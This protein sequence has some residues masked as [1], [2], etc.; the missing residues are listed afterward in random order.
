MDK[1]AFLLEIYEPGSDQT[2]AGCWPGDMPV[3]V[4]VGELIH[5]SVLQPDMPPR[6]LRVQRIE[7]AL[8]IRGGKLAHKLMVFTEP[9]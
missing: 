5:M 6:R 2:V 4:A 8:W 1:S 9:E 3:V 7:H